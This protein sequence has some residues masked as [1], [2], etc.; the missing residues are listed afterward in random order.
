MRSGC[1]SGQIR[2][3]IGDP[4]DTRRRMFQPLPEARRWNC[5]KG[6]QGDKHSGYLCSIK[7]HVPPP[8]SILGEIP[9]AEETDSTPTA[10]TKSRSYALMAVTCV[11]P[12]RKFTSN[13]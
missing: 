7:R 10:L 2:F 3:A 1:G 13:V 5:E 4:E 12:S 9:A 8:V 6:D 11:Y